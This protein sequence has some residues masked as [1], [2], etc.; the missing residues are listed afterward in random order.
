MTKLTVKDNN[1]NLLFPY[2][3]NNQFIRQ[4][5]VLTIEKTGCPC[6]Y[7][8]KG[9]S[10]TFSI[11]YLPEENKEPWECNRWSLNNK[12]VPKTIKNN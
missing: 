5:I 12:F 3:A 9:Q 1:I 11:F 7:N 2:Q 4:G 6:V 8:L 10:M